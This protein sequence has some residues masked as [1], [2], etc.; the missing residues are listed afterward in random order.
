MFQRFSTHALTIIS[1]AQ[2]EASALNTSYVIP[3][4]ILLGILREPDCTA[5]K[6]L[7]SMGIEPDTIREQVL[8]KL[9]HTDTDMEQRLQLTPRSKQL[10]DIA[11]DETR[12]M[13]NSTI[14]S[15]H[16]L[17]AILRQ[18]NG[19]ASEVLK[20]HGLDA[21][22]V[23]ANAEG[24]PDTETRRPTPTRLFETPIMRPES[25]DILEDIVEEFGASVYK[26]HERCRNLLWERRGEYSRE[27]V[28]LQLILQ[29][30][31]VDDLVSAL[32]S[33]PDPS[34]IDAASRRAIELLPLDRMCAV[35]A[36]M[37]WI[38]ALRIYGEP[39]S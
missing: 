1:H 4:H 27:I 5:V 34:V 9:K 2:E 19:A 32:Q 13:K 35:W 38:K 22:K 23:R 18:D 6:I 20:E 26:D 15:A 11:F 10:V 8:S 33:N 25:L 30:G 17:I 39:S 7:V 29:V 24:M 16:L 12:K 28:A 31:I 37:S 36:I 3:E 21:D 14:S